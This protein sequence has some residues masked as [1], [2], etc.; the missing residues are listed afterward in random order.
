MDSVL[1]MVGLLILVLCSA[2]FSISEISL[3]AAKNV[4]L[5]GLSEA[6]DQRAR[7]VIALKANPGPMFTIVE[8]GVNALALAGGILGQDVF[9]PL[10]KSAFIHVLS[11]SFADTAAFWLA[12][13]TATLLFVLFADLIPRRYAMARPESCAI[14]VIRPITWLNSVLKPVVWALNSC[15]TFAM[16]KLGMPT[17][18]GERVTTADV[19]ATVNAGVKEGVIDPEERSVIENIFSLE[20]RTVSTAM[21]ARDDIVY[22][23]K[24]ESDESIRTKVVQN[25]HHQFLVCEKTI[26]NVAGYVDSKQLL[27]RLV[28]GKRLDLTEKGLLSPVKMIPESLSMSETIE[29]IRNTMADFV[30]VINEYGEVAGLIT[31]NDVMNTIMGEMVGLD[32]DAQIVKRDEN[33]WLVEGSTSLYELENTFDLPDIEDNPPY[34]TA[35]GLVMFLLRRIPKRTDKLTFGGY[36][37]EVVDVDKNRVDQLL[38]TKLPKGGIPK[39]SPDTTADTKNQT[40]SGNTPQDISE[41]H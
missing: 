19:L 16:K 30:V 3:A 13:L 20:D 31:L 25:P 32:E 21:T 10:Y 5:Q 1:Q 9:I 12:Y 2:F 26:D 38:V 14:L 33:S 35:G 36:Q 27:T 24:N 39:T 29:E 11:E 6:G 18:A 8:I 4:R 7:E 37:F 41:T 17:H 34:E 23:L 22:F 28:Q 15:T 40:P